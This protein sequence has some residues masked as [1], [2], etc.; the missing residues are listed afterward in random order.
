MT[1]TLR[2]RLLISSLVLAVL[3]MTG[4]FAYSSTE[5]SK[6]TEFNAAKGVS[7]GIKVLP[8]AN[9]TNN[10]ITVLG[11]F[12][13]PPGQMNYIQKATTG[14]YS[15][16]SYFDLGSAWTPVEG[17]AANLH[18]LHIVGGRGDEM[19]F[20]TPKNQITAGTSLD[21]EVQ[22]LKQNLGYKWVNQW[23]MQKK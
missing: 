14:K 3:C 10:G 2:L 4:D 17:K 18:F 11:K 6:S 22:Y 5:S 23:S 15:G 19:I 21:L 20:S 7:P 1:N 8:E 13:A 16:S 9:I 12:Q